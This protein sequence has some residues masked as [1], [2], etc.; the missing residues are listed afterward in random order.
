MV[1]LICFYHRLSHS[2]TGFTVEIGPRAGRGTHGSPAQ[3]QFREWRLQGA[4]NTRGDAGDPWKGLLGS[5]LGHAWQEVLRAKRGAQLREPAGAG[6]AA[7]PPRRGRHPRG[8]AA[9]WPPTRGQG[10]PS[11]MRA[12]KAREG[13]ARRAFD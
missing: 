2:D 5:Q 6:P 11:G 4:G 7:S 12:A 8:T 9:R 10:H 3:T 13:E 1:A